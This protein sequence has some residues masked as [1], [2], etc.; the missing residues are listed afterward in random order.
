MSYYSG[1]LIAVPTANKQ[2]YAD[3]RS[4]DADRDSE[5]EDDAELH[6]IHPDLLH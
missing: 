4:R 1:F 3:R 6:E 5:R 2:A